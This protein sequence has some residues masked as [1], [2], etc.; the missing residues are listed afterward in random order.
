MATEH[1]RKLNLPLTK[2]E[3]PERYRWT[4]DDVLDKLPPANSVNGKTFIVT[5]GHAGL[6]ED[7][8]RALA[9]RGAT[10]ILGSRSES[11]AQDTIDRIRASH[12]NADI[13]FIY[14]DLSDLD[15]VRQFAH[16]FHA[17]GL[18]LHGLFGTNHVGHFLL[19]K[20]LIDDIV[21]SGGGRVVVVSSRGHARSP[22]RFDDLN[23]DGGKLYESW[24][25]YGQSK[26][27]NILCAKEFNRLYS[28]KGVECF[29]LHPGAII[30]TE[31]GRYAEQTSRLVEIGA[32]DTEGNRNP[33]FKTI[34]E[35]AATQ[36]YALTS[37]ELTGKGGAYLV[38]CHIA[39]PSHDQARDV[40]G[41][42]S[43]QL[44]ALSEKLVASYV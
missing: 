16:N 39:E 22:V 3:E 34:P 20:L 42:Y 7:T 8:T 9:T 36:V 40:T 41:E 1:F 33:G 11:R 10:V 21:K 5:G 35:G 25:A 30:D 29:S 6:G 17:T 2:E 14:L 13:R 31:L 43:K 28:A 37:P 24:Q 23:S 26:T 27:A 4:S 32:Y 18:P 12:P 15:K 38:D 19:I 44:H